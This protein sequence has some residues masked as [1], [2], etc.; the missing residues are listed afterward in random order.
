MVEL[1]DYRL[2]EDEATELTKERYDKAISMLEKIESSGF[3]E[4]HD[5]AVATAGTMPVF[6]TNHL[7]SIDR[8]G[9]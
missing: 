3:P 7:A 6:G 5:E 9:Y 8:S 4:F 1:V 2:S